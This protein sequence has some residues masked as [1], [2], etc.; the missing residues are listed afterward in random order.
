MELRRWNEEPVEQLSA[1]I[2]RQLPSTEHLAVARVHLPAG[3][4]VPPYA[5]E[6]EQAA[7]VI[8]GRL[9]LL[10]GDVGLIVAAGESV[11][12][13]AAVSHEVLALSDA[14]V[15]DVFS[16]RPEDWIGGGDA[17]LRG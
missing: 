16:P 4:V 15:I 11:A 7:N 14:L 17:Y 8:E 12:I 3:T 10:V 5:H 13:P 1:G 2:G 9:R 6:N